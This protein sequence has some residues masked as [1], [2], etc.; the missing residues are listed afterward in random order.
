MYKIT[1]VELD[2][3]LVKKAMEVSHKSTIN[4]VVNYSLKELIKMNKKMKL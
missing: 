1:N 4:E 2:V 3:D